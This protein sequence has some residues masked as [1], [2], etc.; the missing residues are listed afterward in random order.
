M[1]RTPSKPWRR[2]AGGVALAAVVLATPALAAPELT[3]E[4]ALRRRA[5]QP[6]Y[7]T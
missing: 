3:L 1:A 4:Q 6:S 2:G 5:G 7:S